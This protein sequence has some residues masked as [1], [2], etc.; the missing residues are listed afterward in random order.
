MRTAVM[1]LEGIADIWYQSWLL[2]RVDLD[3]KVFSEEFSNRFGKGRFKYIA[4]EF[5]KLE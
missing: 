2:N 1:Y 4:Q 3:W 5:S